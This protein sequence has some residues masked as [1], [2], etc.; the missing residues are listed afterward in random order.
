MIVKSWYWLLR[1]ITRIDVNNINSIIEE[2]I[3]N[4][5]YLIPLLIPKYTAG[6]K[7]KL[8]DITRSIS[9]I[10]ITKNVDKVP[11]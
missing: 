11:K 5:P 4:S 8:I 7:I 1:K 3:E 2:T 10:K 9:K 6:P